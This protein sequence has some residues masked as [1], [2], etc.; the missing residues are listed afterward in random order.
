MICAREKG[1]VVREKHPALGEWRCEHEFGQVG[2][3]QQGVCL[4][5]LFAQR[6]PF[7]CLAQCAL[8]IVPLAQ[9]ATEAPLG[10][11]CDGQRPTTLTGPSA[12]ELESALPD[13]GRG[14]LLSGVCRPESFLRHL[15]SKQSA[16]AG[17]FTGRGPW[18]QRPQVSFP[19]GAHPFHRPVEPRE[20]LPPLTRN[21]GR[22]DPPCRRHPARWW[23]RQ[24]TAGRSPTRSG[25]RPSHHA[26]GWGTRGR[27]CCSEFRRSV[28]HTREV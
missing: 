8:Q 6:E 24:G 15:S 5:P 21:L 2:A 14:A 22:E 18:H 25:R 17:R 1:L 3:S 11:P 9:H 7:L 16:L 19:L 26:P 27:D 28:A 12:G 10:V 20:P 4:S 23:D 13:L